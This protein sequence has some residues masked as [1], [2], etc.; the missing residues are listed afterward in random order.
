VFFQRRCKQCEGNQT[1]V[2]TLRSQLNKSRAEVERLTQLLD[3]TPTMPT[4]K[5]VIEEQVCADCQNNG[6]E[7]ER[8][9]TQL[10]NANDE[11]FRLDGA[12]DSLKEQF[13]SSR[14][15]ELSTQEVSS[16]EFD[17]VAGTEERR[18]KASQVLGNAKA[19]INAQ[20]QTLSETIKSAQTV[21]DNDEANRVEGDKPSGS[22][23]FR[24]SDQD[25]LRLQQKRAALKARLGPNAEETREIRHQR[26]REGQSQEIKK[27][28]K[29]HFP[30]LSRNLK[31][32]LVYNEYNA[33]I[34][35]D[36]MLECG[37]FLQSLSLNYSRLELIDACNLI[38]ETVKALEEKQIQDGFAAKEH[39]E[40]GWEFEHW[41]AESFRKFGWQARVT[42]GSGDQGVDVVAE[43]NGVSV[44]IQC[45]R[46]S[47]SVGNKAIQEAY[48]GM[49]HFGLDKAAVLTNANYT[50]SAKELAASTGVLLLSPEDI[51]T[52]SERPEIIS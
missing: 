21:Q 15:E 19:E 3:A 37:K 34:S 12:L 41:V 6:I 42:Q 20:K 14:S 29:Q 22:I 27:A 44:G 39:P 26:E 28:C 49:K 40:D 36:R 4:N 8:L 11:I 31:R 47:G 2:E 9:R 45:K 35:D 46:Y 51:P 17:V 5:P 48:S 18:L 38:I 23:K 43:I 33:L 13:A 1:E 25:R 52:L 24:M 32:C 50:K 7:L 16:K 30:A 10:A